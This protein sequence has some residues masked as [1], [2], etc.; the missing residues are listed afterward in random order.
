MLLPFMSKQN[1]V[2]DPDSY[3]A[4]LNHIAEHP[5]YRNCLHCE[6]NTS[7]EYG[8]QFL[9]GL[10][11]L[12][13][14]RRYDLNLDNEFYTQELIDSFNALTSDDKQFLQD[15]DEALQIALPSK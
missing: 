8:F 9:L 6:H 11:S 13:N 15:F 3:R 2:N 5:H 12:Y 1:C 14:A 7:C 10:R 4:C